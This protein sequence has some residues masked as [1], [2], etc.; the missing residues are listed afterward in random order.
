MTDYRNCWVPL[1]GCRGNA[2]RG[3]HGA[4]QQRRQ[5]AAGVDDWQVVC[6]AWRRGLQGRMYAS[7]ADD[8]VKDHSCVGRWRERNVL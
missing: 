4:R 3:Q 6:G 5:A 2:A 8:V 7:N 1:L